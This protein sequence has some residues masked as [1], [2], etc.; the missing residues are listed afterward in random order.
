M[1]SQGEELGPGPAPP[2][3]PPR[4]AGMYHVG[5][6]GIYPHT[7]GN[8]EVRGWGEGLGGPKAGGEGVL[9]IAK[10]LRV[11]PLGGG[12]GGSPAGQVG[13]SQPGWAPG[14]QVCTIRFAIKLKIF[15]P[16]PPRPCVSL[17]RWGGG[18]AGTTGVLILRASWRRGLFGWIG[19][20]L[21]PPR[22]LGTEDA[23]LPAIPAA[24]GFASSRLAVNGKGFGRL[25]I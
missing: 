13:G 16:G 17:R 2:P 21:G 6:G 22:L 5:E 25:G 15:Q 7:S 11:G 3:S 19:G 8:R 12:G 18:S 14:P 1:G 9:G 10:G 23:G 4:G 20:S 24:D